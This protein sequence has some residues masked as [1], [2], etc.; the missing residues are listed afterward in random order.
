MISIG[1]ISVLKVR[2]WWPFIGGGI[3]LLLLIFAPGQGQDRSGSTYSRDPSGYGA[4]YAYMDDRGT[5][6]QRWRKSPEAWDTYAETCF[7][8]SDRPC[9]LIQI[10]GEPSET[11]PFVGHGK[12]SRRIAVGVKTPATLAP[13]STNH[14][15]PAGGVHLETSRRLPVAELDTNDRVI[16]ADSFGVIAWE[17]STVEE[18]TSL[19]INS[20]HVAANAYQDFTGN[21]EFLAQLATAGGGEVW[22]DEYLHGYRDLDPKG[23]GEASLTWEQYL[24]RSSLMVFV[25]QGGI[26]LMLL[27]MSQNQRF[28]V[29]VPLATPVMDNTIAYIQ[30]LAGVLRQVKNHQFVGEMLGKAEQRHLEKHLGLKGL[31]GLK[32][33]QNPTPSALG[34]VWQAHTGRSSQDLEELLNFPNPCGDTE[35]L[36]WLKKVADLRQHLHSR[37]SPSITPPNTPEQSLKYDR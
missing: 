11:L 33:L 5:P 1:D 36:Q 14:S 28:G 29:R 22:V 16:L 10:Y 34:Q 17:R 37:K 24:G 26:L 6:V 30:A 32:G 21:Y 4:W 19:W 2:Q 20:P 3:L 35:L 12:S 13:Y 9:T 18:G 8:K 15:T 7:G 25:V 27:W 23:E 31:K